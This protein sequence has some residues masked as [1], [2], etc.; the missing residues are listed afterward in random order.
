[1]ADQVRM[2]SKT[3]F[4]STRITVFPKEGPEGGVA[5][6]TVVDG[7][8]F[9]TDVAHAREL[10]A[11][12]RAEALNSSDLEGNTSLEPAFH[13]SVAD[14]RKQDPDWTPA[15]VPGSITGST[16]PIIEPTVEEPKELAV[17]S[18]SKRGAKVR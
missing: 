7:N 10:A 16:T 12:G 11:L 18:G 9:S 2:K 4:A 17:G 13:V 14:M 8:E 15:P 5:G 6:G 3:V 1:M